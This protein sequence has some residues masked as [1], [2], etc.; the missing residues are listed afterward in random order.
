MSNRSVLLAIIIITCRARAVSTFREKWAGREECNDAYVSDCT[1]IISH[2]IDFKSISSSPTIL[3]QKQKFFIFAKGEKK[4]Q[5]Q[6][7]VLSRFSFY[8][9]DF[10]CQYTPNHTTK[11]QKSTHEKHST[12]FSE[13]APPQNFKGSTIFPLQHPRQV[14][15]IKSS[16]TR[17]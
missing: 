1:E 11:T 6:L 17:T 8:H 10:F 3:L 13:Q 14:P 15:A 2:S 16:L 12:C 4:W 7:T 9:L 5:I